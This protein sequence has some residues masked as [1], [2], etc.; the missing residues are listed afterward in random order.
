[1]KAVEETR[2]YRLLK[3]YHKF[4]HKFDL[5]KIKIKFHVIASKSNIFGICAN[6]HTSWLINYLK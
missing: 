1:M 5:I 6:I 2:I 4:S 3:N